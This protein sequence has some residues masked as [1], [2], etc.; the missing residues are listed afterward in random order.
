ME[1]RVN[2][3]LSDDRLNFLFDVDGL[4]PAEMRRREEKWSK[5]TTGGDEE[6]LAA[7]V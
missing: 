6:L 5:G 1:Q 7:A 4:K 3:Q 2:F